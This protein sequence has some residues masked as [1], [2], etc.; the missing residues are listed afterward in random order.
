M[1]TEPAITDARRVSPP[2]PAAAPSTAINPV[3]ELGSVAQALRERAKEILALADRIEEQ[4]VSMDDT[5]KSV[6]ADLEKFR[7]LRSLLGTL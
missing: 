2:V 1:P 3:A 4:A 5:I 7:M 6:G